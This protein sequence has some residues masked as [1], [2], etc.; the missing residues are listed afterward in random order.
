MSTGGTVA[1]RNP[2]VREASMS[3][4]EK[5]EGAGGGTGFGTGGV[6][7][8]GSPELEALIAAV[9]EGAEARDRGLATPRAAIDL[10]KRAGL[11]AFRIP[12]AEGGGGASLFQLFEVTIRLAEADSNIPH[13]LR[14]HFALVEKALRTRGN[15]KYGRWLAQ[16][17][18]G[19]LF[20]L[21]A[22]ELNTQ[23]VGRGNGATVLAPKGSGYVLNGRKFY[24]TGNHYM[25]HIFV[26]ANT[27]QGEPIAAMVAVAQAGVDTTDDWDGMGQRQTASGTT[28]FADVPVPAEE[29]IQHGEDDLKVPSEATFSQLSLTA[30]I[31]GILRAVVRDAIEL[32]RTRNRNF[33]HAVAEV[34]A[35]DPLLQA[36][37]GRLASVAYVAE[38][39]V[40]RAAET[41]G[42]AQA[43][44]E[45]G[46]PDAALFL[47]A[48]LRAAKA[49]VVVD[50][51]AIA[52]AG[53][54]FDVGGATATRQSARL[55][56]H[57]RNIRTLA[58]H[59]PVSYK[60][61]A[62]GDLAV[63]GV[64]LPNASFF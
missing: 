54:L 39:A 59:N 25:D 27:P 43:S 30:V 24:S 47:E 53:Q 23:N 34:P 5:F 12:V 57:W 18:R 17:A 61:R 51:L 52:A 31:A 46:T 58:S 1:E 32:L 10:A 56:R 28:V 11:G 40:L 35:A 48:S 4:A 33:Y 9:A 16:A 63:N 20:G 37:V 38:A 22:N 44:A 8:P 19:D 7:R 50:E 60:A 15:A 21:G 29:V 3:V 6:V 36:T 49:K 45:A 14:N 41:L 42:Q 2:H 26:L 62:I 55:D 13:I 64:P